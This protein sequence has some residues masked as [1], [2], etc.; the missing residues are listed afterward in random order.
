MK[1]LVKQ[2]NLVDILYWKTFKKLK[3]PKTEIQP[4]DDQIFGFLGEQ[5]DKRGFIDL[6]T[7]FGERLRNGKITLYGI[8]ELIL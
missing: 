1:T 5:V 8:S 2:G 6:Y 4:Y 3:I 7:K